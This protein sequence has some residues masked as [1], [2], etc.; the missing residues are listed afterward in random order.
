[1]LVLAGKALQELLKLLNSESSVADDTAHGVFVDW[2][3]TRNG[4]NATAVAHH[5][6]LPL[7]DDFKTSPFQRPNSPKM[8][9]ARELRHD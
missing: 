7:I 5:N 6:V 3:V 2:I 8:V 9:D 1:M 4:K